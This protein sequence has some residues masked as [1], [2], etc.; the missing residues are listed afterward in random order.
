MAQGL[1]KLLL[2]GD[3]AIGERNGTLEDPVD[4]LGQRVAC[5]ALAVLSLLLAPLRHIR[6]PP[7][8]AE[9]RMVPA[10]ATLYSRCIRAVM[11]RWYCLVSA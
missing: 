11:T 4:L 9:G 10:D 3:Q 5:G 8:R 2:H 7:F 1:P 6:S